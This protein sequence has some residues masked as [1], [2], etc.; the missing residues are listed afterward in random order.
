MT[1]VSDRVA[2]EWL[3]EPLADPRV[4]VVEVAFHPSA[5]PPPSPVGLGAVTPGRDNV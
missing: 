3:E 2:P 5:H 1:V 4:V